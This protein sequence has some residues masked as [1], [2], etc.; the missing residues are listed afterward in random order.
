MAEAKAKEV[1][2]GVKEERVPITI[3]YDKGDKFVSVN[4]KNFIL[5]AGQTSM[6]PPYIAEELRRALESE[7]YAYQH[8]EELSERSK[9]MR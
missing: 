9:Q 7:A 5:P 2:A 8:S 4:G 3:P 1:Q 6:V